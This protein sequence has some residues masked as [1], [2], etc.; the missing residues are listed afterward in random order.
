MTT[1]YGNTD[2]AYIRNTLF[3]ENK[4]SQDGGAITLVSDNNMHINNCKFI[5]NVATNG[6]AIH[7]S[8]NAV[9]HITQGSNIFIETEGVTIE[10]TIF[11]RNVASKRGAAVLSSSTEIAMVLRAC[12]FEENVAEDGTR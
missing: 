8:G 1:R 12:T 9:A 6:G 5:K 2:G 3:L 4:S 11:E 7:L 10:N